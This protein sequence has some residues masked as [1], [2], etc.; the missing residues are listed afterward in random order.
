MKTDRKLK[1]QLTLLSYAIAIPALVPLG[2]FP[3]KSKA[4]RN[5]IWDCPAPLLGMLMN[6]FSHSTLEADAGRSP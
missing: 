6:I 5:F 2:S 3:S 4:L 1:P